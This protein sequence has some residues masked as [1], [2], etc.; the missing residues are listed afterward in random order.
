M[1]IEK[2]INEYGEYIFKY[3]LKL[4]CHPQKAEDITQETFIHAWK[5]LEQ[6]QDEKAIK[7][8][9]RTICLNCFL[10]DYRK[11][12]T[13]RL[14]Y[15]EEVEVLEKEGKLISLLPE[16]E[17]EVFVEEAIK[18]LQNGCFYAMVRKLTLKQRMVFSM[19]DMF[20]LE[21]A[22]VAEIMELSEMA[23]K[24]LLYRARMNLDAFFSDHCNLIQ[25]KNPCSCKSWIEFSQ[26]REKNQ[27]SARKLI[28]TLEEKSAE[29]KFD[30]SVRAKIHFLYRNMPDKKPS[31]Q[32]YQD[33]ILGLK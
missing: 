33:I 12:D 9:L 7:K 15:V 32:W 19:M 23:T 14:E 25:A 8:W 11:S 2:L 10:M 4:T 20:G 30:P 6:L 17:E 29:Y 27:Q 5:K 21:L 31:Q 22:E 26:S 24:G 28:D 3:A 18:Q 16:P 13:K 1:T